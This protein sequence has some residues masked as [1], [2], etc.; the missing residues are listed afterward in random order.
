MYQILGMCEFFL[1]MSFVDPKFFPKFTLSFRTIILRAF[2]VGEVGCTI[3][4]KLDLKL[5]SK[6][7]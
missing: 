4:L 7:T 5:Y 1:C 3:T 6:A 2:F